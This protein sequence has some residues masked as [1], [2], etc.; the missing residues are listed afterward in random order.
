VRR[1]AGHPVNQ[2][3]SGAP[4]TIAPWIA[5]A[6]VHRPWAR[7]GGGAVLPR[8]DQ[9]DPIRVASWTQPPWVRRIAWFGH[10]RHDSGHDRH[11]SG[12]DRQM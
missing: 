2:P 3:P 1:V 12:H 5:V 4:T 8:M 7:L 10:D 6:L 9:S 11:D